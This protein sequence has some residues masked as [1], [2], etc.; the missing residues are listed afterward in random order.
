MD[1]KR[2]LNNH[3]GKDRVSPKQVIISHLQIGLT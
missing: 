1:L 2:E 3:A